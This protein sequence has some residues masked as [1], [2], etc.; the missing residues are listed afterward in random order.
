MSKQYNLSS[1]KQESLHVPVYVQICDDGDFMTSLPYE[2][3]LAPP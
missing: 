2:R 3:V 1:N